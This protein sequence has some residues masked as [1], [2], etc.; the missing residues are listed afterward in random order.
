MRPSLKAASSRFSVEM[1]KCHHL[2][3]VGPVIVLVYSRREF[4]S[5]TQLPTLIQ[6]TFLIRVLSVSLSYF[7][8]QK[9]T[10]KMYCI[11]GWRW[12]KF[13]RKGACKWHWNRV[14]GESAMQGTHNSWVGVC[15][16]ARTLVHG[17]PGTHKVPQNILVPSCCVYF[18]AEATEKCQ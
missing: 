3:V 10:V 4:L 5:E 16:V 1:G 2:V 12:Q 7:K 13:G 17:G 9:E 11:L 18:P 8:W 6:S 14:T 15:V